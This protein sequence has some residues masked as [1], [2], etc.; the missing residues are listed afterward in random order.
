MELKMSEFLR[1]L[2][3]LENKVLS[4]R[5]KEGRLEKLFLV[6]LETLNGMCKEYYSERSTTEVVRKNI[7]KN[8]CMEVQR[9][10]SPE[11]LEAM[12]SYLN[13]TYSNIMFRIDTLL[14]NIKP[15]YRQ[16]LIFTYLGLSPKAICT[17]CDLSL[18][19]CYTIRRRLRDI[20]SDAASENSEDLLLNL[21][22][23]ALKS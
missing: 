14:P 1:I 22:K 19:N 4:N 18:E 21:P 12:C 6:E 5:K 16:V 11:M 23:S 20:I 17:I 13:E 8:I 3:D 15:I 2:E 10:K 7:Y 9:I